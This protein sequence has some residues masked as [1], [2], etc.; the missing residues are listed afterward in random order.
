M[1]GPRRARTDQSHTFD[2]PR[3]FCRF[4][5]SMDRLVGL[6]GSQQDSLTDDT[7]RVTLCPISHAGRRVRI[8]IQRTH[9]GSANDR[10]PPASGV[11]AQ[12]ESGGSPAARLRDRESQLPHRL[13]VVLHLLLACDCA[14]CSNHRS[15]VWLNRACCQDPFLSRR[16]TDLLPAGIP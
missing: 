16:T 1:P 8:I 4:L 15:A 9:D 10:Q 11:P 14:D 6:S 2:A 7:K 13:P 12:Q 5:T 3:S